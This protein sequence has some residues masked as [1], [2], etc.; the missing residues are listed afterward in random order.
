MKSPAQV[1]ARE[2]EEELGLSTASYVPEYLGEFTAHAANETQHI[3]KGAGRDA[4]IRLEPEI[5]IEDSY[6][7]NSRE[8][9]GYPPHCDA[10]S[11]SDPESVA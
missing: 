4:K 6:G 9:F 2:I 5:A 11:R 3:V 10:E 7:F 8:P 1:L